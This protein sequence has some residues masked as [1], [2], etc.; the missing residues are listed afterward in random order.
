MSSH[1]KIERSHQRRQAYIYIRQST[2]RQVHENLESQALQYQLETQAEALGWRAE[3][4]VVIDEDLGKSG[5]SSVT[6]TGFQRLF[7]DV[8][9]GKVGM[10]LVTDVSRIARNSA[11][12][13]RLLELAAQ[14]DV[15]VSDSSG[16]YNPTIYADRLLLGIQGAF[17]EAQ[18]YNMRQQTKEARLHKAKRGELNL[19][20]PVGLVRLPNDEVVKEPDGQVQS[21]LAWLFRTFRQEGSVHQLLIR[22]AKAGIQMPR[23]GRNAVGQAIITWARPSYEAIYQVLKLPAYAGAYTYGKR[24]SPTTPGQQRGRNRILDPEAWQVLIKDAFPAYI[25]WDEYMENQKIMA[26]NWRAT[27]FANPADAKNH[28]IHNE[29]F[30]P[31]N[32]ERT[33]GSASDDGQGGFSA[34]GKGRALLQGIVYC[35]HCGRPMRVRY[36]D[37][38]AYVCEA[39]KQAFNEPRCGF[40][41]Y[42]HVDR[43]VVTA[44]LHAIE[45][46][47]IEIALAAIDQREEQRTTLTQQWQQQ[48]D[49]ARYDVTLA[50]IR[51]EQVDP[52]MRLVAA[53]LE[54]HWE[55]KLTT[56]AQLEQQWEEIQARELAPLSPAD[57]AT[58]RNLAH[59]L[60]ALWGAETTTSQERKR[61][62]R[63]IIQDVT[64]AGNKEEGSTTIHLTWQS[65]DTSTLT[66]KR[67]TP[68]HPS[69]RP[70]LD[71]VRTL[72][73]TLTDDKI[74]HILNQEGLISS[75]HVKDD[76][77]YVIGQPVSYWTQARVRH[78]RNKHQIPTGMPHLTK[79]DTP[80]ADGLIPAKAAARQLNVTPSVVIQ[81]FRRGLLPGQQHR[82]G[83]PVWIQLDDT[84][85]HRFHAS[86]DRP[87]PGMVLLA[88]APQHFG[89]SNE[90]L[91]DAIRRQQLFTWRLAH[92]AQHRWFIAS[93]PSLSARS[94]SERSDP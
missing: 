4:I 26:Q 33:R 13:H 52:T 47:A 14:N 54:R 29:P 70:L 31:Y 57:E 42:A 86:L 37:K 44:F 94:I 58:I 34:V 22:M 32:G 43:A 61:L 20:L 7:T 48:L 1:P 50:Q 85:R 90:Q 74:A 12:W 23:Q 56:L 40:Y 80:R 18:W 60:P 83:T 27:P 46:A 8:G 35:G 75:W 66:A 24:K 65:G 2:M 72:A 25:S 84:N 62:L 10:I 30:S 17:A 3:Q 11:D 77:S 36:R 6:R 68:G 79:D 93:Y 64:L 81:W 59:D 78:L 87:A 15:L 21:A 91:L 51:Y 73:Q 71:R 53:Q 82:P 89:L 63:T 28:G 5:I 16:V 38:P 69:N 45:P 49:R 41:P 67:P 19:R 76:P 88:D 55:E 39:T 9:L 92:G